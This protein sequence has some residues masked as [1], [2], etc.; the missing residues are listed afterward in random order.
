M[1]DALTPKFKLIKPDF[2]QNIGPRTSP[3]S[4][5]IDAIGNSVN[6][7]PVK[8]PFPVET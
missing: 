8:P 2:K 6:L 3:K 5:V 7:Y 4:F 1:D